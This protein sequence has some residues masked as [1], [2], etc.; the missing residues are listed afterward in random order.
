MALLEEVH[1]WGVRGG[2]L[3]LYSLPLLPVC[4]FCFELAIEGVNSRLSDSFSI[5][6]VCFTAMMDPCPFGT[7]TQNKLSSLGCLGNTISS[8]KQKSD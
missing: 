2:A 7:T 6:A 5:L 8:Q 3:R 4:L 1:H